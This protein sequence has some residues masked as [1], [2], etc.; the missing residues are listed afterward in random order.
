MNMQRPAPTPLPSV[1]LPRVHGLAGQGAAFAGPHFL[2]P[3]QVNGGKTGSRER[4]FHFATMGARESRM[5]DF[6]QTNPFSALQS[7]QPAAKV[8]GTKS[9]PQV[10]RR[11]AT[12]VASYPTQSESIRVNPSKSE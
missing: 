10:A 11:D 7:R 6:C 1:F 8:G 3:V 2:H 5:G 12:A 9:R 4:R